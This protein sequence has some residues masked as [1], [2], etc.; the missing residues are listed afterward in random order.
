MPLGWSKLK[1]PF[2]S[3][4]KDA[5]KA[6]KEAPHSDGMVAMASQVGNSGMA[7]LLST[8]SPPS[9]AVQPFGSEVSQELD[10]AMNRRADSLIHRD[11]PKGYATHQA[12]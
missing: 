4:K 5:A 2:G 10:Q 1:S 8:S 12:D 3:R 6:E 7:E 9:Q 11:S